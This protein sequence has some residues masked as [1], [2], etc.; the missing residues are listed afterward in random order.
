MGQT[1]KGRLSLGGGGVPGR[2]LMWCVFR[3]SPLAAE[4]RLRAA[5]RGRGPFD[6]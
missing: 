2:R 3:K 4:R 6:E 5:E 1:R